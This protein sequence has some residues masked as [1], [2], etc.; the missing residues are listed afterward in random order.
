MSLPSRDYA[1]L[2]NDSYQDRVADPAKKEVINGREYKVLATKSDFASGYQGTIY[3][4]VQSR[5]IVV[6]HRGSEAGMTRAVQD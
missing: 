3:L 2:S 5:E 4:D 1:A 6:A